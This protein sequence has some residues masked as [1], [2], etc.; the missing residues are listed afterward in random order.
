MSRTLFNRI[1]QEVTNHS[2]FFRDN[3]DC[4]GREGISP[5]MKC[6]SAIRQLAYD[7][8]PDFLDEYLQIST[9]SSRLSLDHF[10]TS[11][12]EIFGPEYLRKPMMTNVVKLYRHH[13]EKHGFSGMLGSFDCTDWEWFGC[14][15]GHKG[16]YVRRDHGPNPFIL[17]EA[18]PSQDLW[19]WHAFFG[20]SGSNNDINVKDIPIKINVFVWKVQK[21]KLPS[22]LNLARLGVDIPSLMCPIFEEGGES[23]AHLLF[24]V[25][26]LEMSCLR[27][28]KLDFL[29]L[30]RTDLPSLLERWER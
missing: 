10:C 15:Y 29:Q 8:V 21:D 2:S 11:V 27:F 1:V 22:R 19:I 24:H 12:M 14:P 18:V 20:V 17:L 28:N 13:E 26:C 9:K 23:L 30:V 16:Q 4:T 3:I 7:I 25:R 6:T 5:L